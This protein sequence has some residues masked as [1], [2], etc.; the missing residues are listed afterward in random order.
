M[1]KG[2]EGAWIRVFGHNPRAQTPPE[3]IL[4]LR[5]MPEAIFDSCSSSG[6][7]SISYS[8]YLLDN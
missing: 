4:S 5:G 1:V 6:T 7:L 3:R 2:L 8:V